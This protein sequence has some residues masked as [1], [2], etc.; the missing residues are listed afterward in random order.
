MH[1][2]IQSHNKCSVGLTIFC[3]IF[4]T[5]SMNVGNISLNILLVP[6]NIVMVLNNVMWGV[7]VALDFCSSFS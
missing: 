3:G 2:I 4:S 6:H 1:N 5:F 7:V